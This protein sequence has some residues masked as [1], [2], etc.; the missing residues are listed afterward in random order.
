MGR[1]FRH[2]GHPLARLGELHA[3]ALVHRGKQLHCLRLVNATDPEGFRN[4]IGS[5]VVM[6]RTDAAGSKHVAVAAAQGIERLHDRVLVVGDDAHLAQIDATIVSISARWPM[7]L[8]LVRPERSSSPMAS[9]AAV[10]IVG[11][12]IGAPGVFGSRRDLVSVEK[13]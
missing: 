10:T 3:A 7:F 8:S 4:R 5:D 12:V 6:G 11:L 13:S 9:M 2:A 1:A